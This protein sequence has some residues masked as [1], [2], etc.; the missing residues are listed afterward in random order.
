MDKVRTKDYRTHD[1]KR[2]KSYTDEN[3][4]PSPSQ[5]GEAH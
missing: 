5:M 1:G 3:Y 2:A 4:P